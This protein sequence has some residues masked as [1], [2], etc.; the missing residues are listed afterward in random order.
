MGPKGLKRCH[1]PPFDNPDI[2][3][4]LPDI[5]VHR[6]YK[7]AGKD[8]AEVGSRGGRRIGIFRFS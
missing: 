8:N 1:C 2:E 6:R 4:R 3:L 7:E 5:E